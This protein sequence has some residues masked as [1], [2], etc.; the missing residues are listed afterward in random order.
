MILDVHER[1]ALIS[2]LPAQED[3]KALKTI[4]R[5]REM[6]SFTPD[7]MPFMFRWEIHGPDRKHL[8]VIRS[9]DSKMGVYTF[10]EIRS[11]GRAQPVANRYY[12][13]PSR[14]EGVYVNT[15]GPAPGICYLPVAAILKMVVGDLQSNLHVLWYGAKF[16]GSHS[17]PSSRAPPGEAKLARKSPLLFLT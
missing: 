2:L 16:T 3:Y 12:I 15:F 14:R 8:A 6:L 4:R 9:W 7:E 11:R 5:A 13:V 10:G 1:L 17:K